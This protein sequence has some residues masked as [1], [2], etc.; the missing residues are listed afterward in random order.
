MEKTKR[1]Q[2]QD[3]EAAKSLKMVPIEFRA[4]ANKIKIAEH[5]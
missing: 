3:I 4:T 1:R 5:K 2:K